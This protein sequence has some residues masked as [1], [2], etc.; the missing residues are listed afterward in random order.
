MAREV[1]TLEVALSRTNRPLPDVMNPGYR[2]RVTGG[3]SLQNLVAGLG[4]SRDK[5]SYTTYSFPRPVT[6]DLAENMFRTSHLAKTVVTAVPDDAFREWRKFTFEQEDDDTTQMDML[7]EAEIAF[8]V[9]TKFTE[10][11]YWAR[12]YGGAMIILGMS[13]AL[14]AAD[15]MKPLDVTKVKQGD[16]KFLH[17]VDRWRCAPSGKV[18]RD[19]LSGNFGKP[20]SYLF[21]EAALEIHHTRIIRWDGQKLPYFAWRSNGM[22]DDSELQH[23]YD[24]I[25]KYDTA[26][27]SVAAMLWEANV[28]VVH[29]KNLTSLLAT[30]E[31]ETKIR[32]RFELGQMMKNFNRTLIMDG[33]ETYDKKVNN[34]ANIDKII[35][36]YRTDIQGATHI[37]MSRLFGEQVGG[38]GDSGEGDL[39]N[40]YDFVV[41]ERKMKADPQLNY[42]DQVF[43]RSV[44]GVMPVGYK[45]EWNSLWQMDDMDKSKIELQDAQRDNFYL[46]RGVVHEG[47]VAADLRRRGVYPLMTSEDVQLAEELGQQMDDHESEMR[48]QLE[49]PPEPADNTPP[50]KKK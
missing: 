17:V 14:T 15:M 11:W 19:V 22:W 45:S 13:D 32:K 43:V 44:L 10:A 37:A 42:F 50:N 46:Q 18:T 36:E 49:N 8:C 16:L 25:T 34:F 29:V 1:K 35:Q 47:L 7:T 41:K 9:Q 31:G 30:K 24:P 40:Y 38:L 48:D 39:T 33:D 12:L 2:A 26:M 20:D 5:S 6:R 4:T 28:D 23:V 21:A 3:D 27:S